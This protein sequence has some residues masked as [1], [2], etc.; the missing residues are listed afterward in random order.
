M[1]ISLRGSGLDGS[2]F[3]PMCLHMM[4]YMSFQC[5]IEFHAHVHDFAHA[6]VDVCVCVLDKSVSTCLY[7]H[8]YVEV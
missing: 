7:V 2:V 8:V 5:H 1:S 3:T 6:Y 4:L